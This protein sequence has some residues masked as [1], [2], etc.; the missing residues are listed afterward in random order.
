[1]LKNVIILVSGASAARAIA[2]LFSPL[3]T[4]LFDPEAFGLLGS[5]M[6]VV[7]ITGSVA[8]LAYPIAILLPAHRDE[9]VDL[10]YLSIF[11]GAVTSLLTF[12]AAYIFQSELARVI[13]TKV[14]LSLTVFLPVSIGATTFLQISQQWAIRHKAFKVYAKAAFIVSTT[15]NSAKAIVGVFYPV[16]EV[17][18]GATILGRGLNSLLLYLG[19]RK[20]VKRIGR[21]DTSDDGTE[22][23]KTSL[24]TNCRRKTIKIIKKYRD[25]PLYRAPQILINAIGAYAP[26]FVLTIAYGKK[27]AGYYALCTT[28][29]LAPIS[30]INKSVRDVFYSEISSA[31][32]QYADVSKTIMTGTAAMLLIMLP[33]PIVLFIV[34]PELFVITF[35][36]KWLHAGEYARWLSIMIYFMVASGPSIAAIPVLNI[37]GRFLGFEILASGIRV[38]CL[39]Y[40]ALVS[41]DGTMAIAIFSLTGACSYILLIGY[42]LLRT[43][44]NKRLR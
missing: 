36:G 23:R 2:L 16:A 38:V 27:S 7:N 26:L 5:Y 29:I 35:G 22:D 13:G 21:N 39:A 17:L 28:A 41:Y 14:T 12:V 8:A 18:I 15:V 30:I 4:R 19:S 31:A 42:V 10:V 24:N 9:A 11:L 40:Y 20:N 32:H 43:R 33:V 6:G 1:M 37:Q 25:F 34:G 3:L 44:Y